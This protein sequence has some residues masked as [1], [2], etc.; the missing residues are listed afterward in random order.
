[1]GNSYAIRKKP[2][3]QIHRMVLM[4]RELLE[5]IY[6]HGDFLLGKYEGQYYLFIGEQ[7]CQLSDHPYEPCLYIKAINKKQRCTY[8]RKVENEYMDN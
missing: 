5:T 6:Q 3:W 7:S 8:S 1:M 2:V 4:K